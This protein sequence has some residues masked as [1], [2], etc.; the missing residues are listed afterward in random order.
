MSVSD[1]QMNGLIGMDVIVPKRPFVFKSLSCK[2][3]S[4]LIDGNTFPVFDPFLYQ[5]NCMISLGFYYN[6]IAC[7]R[8]YA[9]LH[10][11]MI[12]FID[13]KTMFFKICHSNQSSMSVPDNQMN[14]PFCMGMT[15]SYHPSVFKILT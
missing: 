12:F 10:D 7:Y 5:R 8:L 6:S 3:K 9:D 4:L 1:Y 13:I 2:D 11:R 14:D 15:V